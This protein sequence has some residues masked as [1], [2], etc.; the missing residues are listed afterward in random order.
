MHINSESI[1]N[2][3]NDSDSQYAKPDKQRNWI[4]QE[5]LICD[6]SPKYWFNVAFDEPK[7]KCDLTTK[8]ELSEVI[9]IEIFEI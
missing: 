8:C 3:T 2:E 7:I 6:A 9:E 4:W 1:S 5:I